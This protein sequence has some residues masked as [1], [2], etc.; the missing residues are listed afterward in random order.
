[1]KQIFDPVHGFISLTPLMTKIID[2]SDFQRLRDLR[3][4]GTAHY[5]FPSANHTRAEHSIGVAHLAG[6]MMRSL[7]E[8]QPELD[9]SDRLIELVQVAGLVH[10]IGHGPFSH[11]FDNYKLWPQAP[12]HEGRGCHIFRALVFKYNIPL[13]NEEVNIIINMICPTVKSGW[14][15]QVVANAR[16]QI[17]VDKIDYIIRDCYHIGL[18]CGSDFTRIV[19]QCRVIDNTICFP[20]KIRYNIFTLFTTRYRLHKQIYNHPTVIAYEFIVVEILKEIMA[21]KPHFEDMTDSV[22][23]CRFHHSPHQKKLFER[24]HKVMIREKMFHPEEDREKYSMSPSPNLET[25][26]YKIG[27]VSGDKPNPMDHVW[28]YSRR[29]PDQK[30]KLKRDEISFIVPSTFQE[31]GIRWYCER[32]Q[33]AA[34][35]AILNEF[36]K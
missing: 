19:T 18:T 5:V 28:F 20:E 10:D 24:K 16:N 31:S 35:E 30:F 29:T 13:S 11:V 7:R 27:F 17:D 22:V 14:P 6:T 36:L 26:I 4:L 8:N 34:M 23:T 15:Y 2:T 1:M 9:I 21:R 32:D 3:Q 12:D 25:Q 33:V